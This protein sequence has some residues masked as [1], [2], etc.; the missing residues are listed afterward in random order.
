MLWPPESI[1][2][3]R[4]R[5]LAERVRS[6]SRYNS[7]LKEFWKPGSSI[8]QLLILP[9][10]RLLPRASTI[11]NTPIPRLFDFRLPYFPFAE[12]VSYELAVEPAHLAKA[13]AEMQSELDDNDE[14]DEED[15]FNFVSDR[16]MQR[17]VAH[18]II[19]TIRN[20]PALVR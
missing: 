20:N 19:L 2:H 5:E 3:R 16:E 12:P 7:F 6:D 14:E 1:G 4:L 11:L 9:R 8:Q 15:P 17:T 13:P 10:E 18:G